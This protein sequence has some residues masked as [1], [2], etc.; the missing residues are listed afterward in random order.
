M[1][2][3]AKKNMGLALLTWTKVWQKLQGTY[4]NPTVKG[5]PDTIGNG[6]GVRKLTKGLKQKH[7]VGTESS[8][9]PGLP[10][11]QRNNLP[12]MKDERVYNP[13]AKTPVKRFSELRFFTAGMAQG[14]AT[15][16]KLKFDADEVVLRK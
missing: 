10:T 12:S 8:V 4:Q 6:N 7:G 15:G 16:N 3:V 11:E 1:E 13:G 9:G 5:T 14:L 2:L